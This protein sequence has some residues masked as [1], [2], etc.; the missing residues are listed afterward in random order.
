MAPLVA[1]HVDWKDLDRAAAF[2]ARAFG[3]I[4][5]RR[6]GPGAV[7]LLGARVPVHL[8]AHRDDARA[9]DRSHRPPL[10]V[11]LVV[12]DLEGSCERARHAG[13]ALEGRIRHYDW[14]SIAQLADP[15]GN[16]ICLLQFRSRG[17]AEGAVAWDPGASARECAAGA[18][19]A[20][21]QVHDRGEEPWQ[22]PF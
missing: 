17:L 12:E 11:D 5:G 7:E 21:R 15:F 20:A 1:L 8:L 22:R 16:R 13:A 6:L 18:L 2:Y 4:I 10:Q 3:L 9:A 14:G 19:Q